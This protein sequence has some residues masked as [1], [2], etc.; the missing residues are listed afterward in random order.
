MRIGRT[1]RNISIVLSILIAT[2]SCVSS[3][4]QAQESKL[5]PQS[6][7]FYK[8]KMHDGVV[9]IADCRQDTPAGRMVA[10]AFQGVVNQQAGKVYLYLADHHVNQ[11]KDT[12][13]EF[14]VLKTK[15]EGPNPGLRSLFTQYSSQIENIYVWEPDQ[16]WT[17]NIAVM[18]SAQNSGL[19]L[20]KE[21]KD[22]LLT[23]ADWDGNIIELGGKWENNEDAYNWA[24]ENLMPKCHP[25]LIFSVGL[26][27]DWTHNPWVLYDYATASR[28]FAFWLDDADEHE[29]SIIEKICEAGKYQPGS[30]VMGYAQSGDD[31]LITVNK[32]GIGYVVSDYYSNGSFWCSYPNKAF[33]QKE[34]KAHQVEAGKIY[35]SVTLSDGD[36]VQFDQNALYELW[37]TDPAR[38]TMPMGTTMAAGLQELNPFLL[39]WFYDNMTDN[40][41]LM[42]GPSGYQFIYGRDYQKEG[43]EKWLKLNHDWIASAGFHVG[44][45]WHTT[46]G[47]DKFDRYIETSGLKGIFDGDDRVIMD[48][49]DGVIIMNQGDHLVE[50][51]DLYN[52][53]VRRY[54]E[55][56]LSK[57]LFINTYPIAAVWGT[58]G[59]SRMKR[60]VERLEKEF[61]GVFVFMLPKDLVATASKYYDENPDQIPTPGIVGKQEP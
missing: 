10:T 51:G 34:G 29:Q 40:D 28:G 55:A 57:P 61:P 35:V 6:G 60:E 17:W 13:R 8:T 33:T 19:P 31:L 53:L 48:Y 14:E 32:Y 25:N 15:G 3:G 1:I 7:L 49:R 22:E 59:F 52:N 38:G 39:E 36:N 37:R 44:C 47:S 58:Q 50:E 42:A 24:I 21:Q 9:E 43:Y 12:K 41:E 20:L 46:Y 16:E 56:D 23:A 26:R 27:S 30:A 4:E 54:N 11:F 5:E 18:Q 2:T 45:F